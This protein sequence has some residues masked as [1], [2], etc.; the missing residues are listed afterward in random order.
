MYI[1]ALNEIRKASENAITL[2]KTLCSTK[3]NTTL[4]SPARLVKTSTPKSP[5]N[6]QK[7]NSI[8][9]EHS[10]QNIVQTKDISINTPLDLDLSFQ[11]DA[12][13]DKCI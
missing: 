13:T 2:D 4:H 11:V 12:L 9:L 7:I 8:Q 3:Q 10:P 5:L 6:I 1:K